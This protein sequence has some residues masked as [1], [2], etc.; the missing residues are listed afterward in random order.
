MRKK[1]NVLYKDYVFLQFYKYIFLIEVF[2]RRV[3]CRKIF[4]NIVDDIKFFLEL[5]LYYFFYGRFIVFILVSL[6]CE[7][8]QKL[9]DM[10][11]FIWFLMWEIVRIVLWIMSIGENNLLF[12]KVGKREEQEIFELFIIII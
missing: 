5:W 6:M 12:F 4:L 10:G 11:I 8:G 9:G 3:D 2:D 7:Q 1:F